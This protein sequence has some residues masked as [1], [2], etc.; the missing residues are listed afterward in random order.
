[1]DKWI[2]RQDLPKQDL[3]KPYLMC[4]SCDNDLGAKVENHIATLIM[5]DK[6]DEMDS[7]DELNIEMDT[8][9]KVVVFDA[10][11]H[12]GKYVCS[13]NERLLLN[14]FS[15]SVAWRVLH[16]M[17]KEGK[18]LS[19]KYLKTTHGESVNKTTINHIFNDDPPYSLYPASLYYLGPK[20]ASF[21]TN[22]IDEYPFAWAELGTNP[23]DLGIGVV[24]GCW[25]VIWPLGEGG[26][27]EYFNH[28]DNLEKICFESWLFQVKS[29]LAGA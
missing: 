26:A 2:N 24:F 20:S 18:P 10:P 4:E 22:A 27:G 16:A 1:M 3:P 8:L 15:M 23:S 5:P 21:I 29:D 25:V 19:E 28:L 14:K 13:E 9:D 7:W 12:V 17:A 6:V 11:F